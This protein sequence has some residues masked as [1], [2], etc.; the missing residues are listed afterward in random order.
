[1]NK[2]IKVSLS[3]SIVA[4][5]SSISNVYA[6]KEISTEKRS[7]VAHASIEFEL[8]ES[9]RMGMVVNV[10]QV[11]GDALIEAPTAPPR[12]D[13][14]SMPNPGGDYFQD[15]NTTLLHL[16]INGVQMSPIGGELVSNDSLKKHSNGS[17]QLKIDTC[18]LMINPFLS[19]KDLVVN[20]KSIDAK[21]VVY[22]ANL[23]QTDVTTMFGI[24]GNTA[25]KIRTTHAF[26]NISG[27][28]DGMPSLDQSVAPLPMGG[29]WKETIKYAVE[30][31][32]ENENE[33]DF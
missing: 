33:N 16:T 11:M 5:L 7:T 13:S 32:N 25:I 19:C 26:A 31:E 30:N 27:E 29:V 28:F 18:S 1:M 2:I 17:L 12:P 6:N 20:W 15:S 23:E 21:K 9:G 10:S 24:V 22:K 3:L 4:I 8:P 14:I